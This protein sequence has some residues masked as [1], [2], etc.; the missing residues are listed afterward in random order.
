[1]PMKYRKKAAVSL[2]A[3]SLWLE[4]FSCRKT[5][6]WQLAIGSWPLAFGLSVLVAGKSAF[7]H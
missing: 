2:L 5:G 1:M 3:F 4:C 6:L 7:G